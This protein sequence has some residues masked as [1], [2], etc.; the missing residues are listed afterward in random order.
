MLKDESAEFISTAE[1]ERHTC[2]VVRPRSDCH[3]GTRV[4]VW[5][6][7]SDPHSILDTRTCSCSIREALSR[8]HMKR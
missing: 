7:R 2:L 8:Y 5:S 3:S 6:E 1:R 4:E